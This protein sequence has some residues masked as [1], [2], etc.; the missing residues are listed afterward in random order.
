METKTKLPQTLKDAIEHFANP[1]ACLEYVA[2]RRWADGVV[3][4]HCQSKRVSFIS[5]RR[6]WKCLD[7]RKQ[8]SVK[9]GTI[10]EDSPISLSKWLAAMWMIANAKN[11]ISSYEIARALGVT[12][13]TAWF[14]LHRI[15]KAMQDQTL[16][17]LSGEIE[18]DETFIGGKAENMHKA[19]KERMI[20]GRGATGKTAVL[21]ILKRKNQVRTQVIPD[22]ARETIQ[23]IMGKHVEVGSTIYTDAMPSYNDLDPEYLHEIIDHAVA[24]VNGRVH[25][26]GIENYWSLLK[27]CL[28]GTYIHVDPDHL[29]RYLDEESFRFNSRTENDSDRFNRAVS[30]IAGK[31]LSYKQ[32]IR[33]TTYKQLAMFN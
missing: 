31:S 11:G 26:N 18:A 29:F 9:V 15:R 4:P 24:Y 6:I 3:C 13:K 19:R 2:S 27:R 10:F 20:H 7:C 25:T 23:P 17:K 16:E 33:K 8:F 21:G 5:T 32:L 30:S 1:D 28:K 14:M 12:Q 22:T